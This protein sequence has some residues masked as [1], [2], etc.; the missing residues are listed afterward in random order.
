MRTPELQ[1]ASTMRVLW[2]WVPAFAGTTAERGE[3]LPAPAKFVIKHNYSKTE[4]ISPWETPSPRKLR[5]NQ[6]C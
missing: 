1:L 5:V 3:G 2:L 4:A 6:N